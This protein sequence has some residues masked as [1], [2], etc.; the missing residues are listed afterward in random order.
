MK[1]SKKIYPKAAVVIFAALLSL[2]LFSACGG[3]SSVVRNEGGN[4]N[5]TETSRQ[6]LQQRNNAIPPQLYS[7]FLDFEAARTEEDMQEIFEQIMEQLELVLDGGG[8][9]PRTGL[10]DPYIEDLAIEILAFLLHEHVDIF[11]AFFNAVPLQNSRLD[12]FRPNFDFDNYTVFEMAALYELTDN[13]QLR[14][15]ILVYLA[16][17]RFDLFINLVSVPPATPLPERQIVT[18]PEIRAN[19]EAF[20]GVESRVNEPVEDLAGAPGLG[21]IDTVNPNRFQ[22]LLEQ[23]LEEAHRYAEIGVNYDFFER[24][25]TAREAET[26]QENGD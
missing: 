10:Y 16:Q 6:P 1:K 13:M 18:E 8:F 14:R 22:E 11:L 15:S 17:N 2:A 26:T 23:Y 12:A 9:D 7:L 21:I 5:P 25:R 4:P 3:M 20:V 19:L 24:S